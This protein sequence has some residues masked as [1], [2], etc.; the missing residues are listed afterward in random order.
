[1]E[2]INEK[3]RMQGGWVQA[4]IF[5]WNWRSSGSSSTHQYEVRKAHQVLAFVVRSQIVTGNAYLKRE[6]KKT[7]KDSIRV[8]SSY[9]NENQCLF[10]VYRCANSKIP[11][12]ST[13][14][15]HE[16]KL[17]EMRQGCVKLAL[18]TKVINWNCKSG[19]GKKYVLYQH[20]IEIM[21]MREAESSASMWSLRVLTLT[22]R[23]I[24]NT[25]FAPMAWSDE[26]LPARASAAI[27]PAKT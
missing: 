19:G 15:S 17:K 12:N 5:L 21:E 24:S 13:N 9:A 1:M 3:R 2:G 7:V 6:R 14:Q 22:A 26:A 27:A 8:N 10:K 25:A 11:A 18:G 16:W 20:C 23:S 4:R